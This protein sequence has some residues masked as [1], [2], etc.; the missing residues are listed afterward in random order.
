MPAKIILVSSLDICFR[1]EK[2]DR[3][4]VIPEVSTCF[5]FGDPHF[6]T[7]DDLVI[8]FQGPCKYKMAASTHTSPPPF[9]IISKNQHRNGDPSVT[10]PQ[11]MELHVFDRI[12]VFTRK[13]A[14]VNLF[15][16][17]IYQVTSSYI[18]VFILGFS[19]TINI[20]C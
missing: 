16:S 4:F 2:Q 9:Q 20:S 11:N 19:I 10:Y 18:I 1:F 17:T 3:S 13:A 6:K 8:T 5:T 12:I 14:K 7:F 15:T